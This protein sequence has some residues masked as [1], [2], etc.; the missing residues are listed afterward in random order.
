[1]E[2]KNQ[3]LFK[4]Y[5]SYINIEKIL[6]SNNVKRPLLVCDGAYDFL[7]VKNYIENLNYDFVKFSD[8]TP[9]PLYEDIIKGVKLFN[10]NE[11]DFIISIGGGSAIDVAKC[12]K[13]YCK[14]DSSKTYLEQEYIDSGIKHLA[15][16][17]TAGTGSESTRFAVCYYEG[18]K[19]SVT[20]QSIIPDYAILEP[21]F[22]KTLPLY[23][24]K[25]TLLDA[26]CQGIESLW[27]VNSN[28]ES[29]EY[30][31]LA[32]KG[33]LA[34]LDAY[35]NDDKD[36]IERIAIAANYAGKAIN[37]TQTTA[38]HAMSYKITSL[39]GLAHGHAVAVCLPYVWR[40]MIENTNKCSD[41]RGEE[42]LESVFNTLD[43]L[44]FVDEHRQAVYRF[45]RILKLLEIDFP[46]L[47]S[48][49]EMDILVNSVNPTRL[50]NNPVALDN[51]AILTI[52]KNVFFDGNNFPPKNISKFL[53]K[54]H[55]LYEVGELQ[56]YSLG[57]LKEFDKFCTEHNLEY[58]AIE[59]TLLGAV[60]H[61][62]FIPWDD[63]I[64]VC[65]K[66]EE[67]NKFIKLASES[68]GNDY[69]LDSFETNKKHWTVCAKLQIAKP[70]KFKIKRLE[71]IALSISPSIDIFP[72][73]AV[74]DTPKTQ[75]AYEKVRFWK[76]LLWLKTG[77]THDYAS[78]KY[79]ILKFASLFLP[80][81]F[82]HNKINGIPKK[83][84]KPNNEKY[85]NFGSLYSYKKEIFDAECFNSST[86]IKFCDTE[87]PVPLG[88]QQV[89]KTTYGE[90]NQLPPFS[91][92]FPKHSYFVESNFEK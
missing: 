58:F 2:F 25:A 82:I 34:N 53:K 29:K 83:V 33:I 40:Y 5:N 15:I 26:L 86:K 41:S 79:S 78:I 35:L 62:G 59:G 47:N 18:V 1:M 69:I 9:N 91:H 54:Y 85:I 51:D 7:F 50:G 90:Y 10:E 32:I 23:Q 4:G 19:Q 11:C 28:E 60:R 8:F 57:I 64:D 67:Y 76:I 36:A 55:T 44:F 56:D 71:N 24:K 48:P 45:F 27:S 14:M 75:K 22:L 81:K 92:R 6:N 37:I 16:P 61:N 77:Y 12:I 31:V 13:L 70:T 30:S 84:T 52:Y 49:D 88:F 80:T 63:D 39:Y 73:D 43:E 46:T 87:I 72:I 68:F 42:H 21:E 17:T 3:Q 20:H 66:R 65:M 38:A 89:L 74:N